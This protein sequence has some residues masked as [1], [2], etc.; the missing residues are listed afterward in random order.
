M[1]IGSGEL[2]TLFAATAGRIWCY[3]DLVYLTAE[4]FEIVGAIASTART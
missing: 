4:G 1:S 2:P 3:A